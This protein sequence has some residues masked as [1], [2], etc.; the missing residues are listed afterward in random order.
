MHFGCGQQERND[1]PVD[2]CGGLGGYPKFEIP[3]PT[4]ERGRNSSLIISNPTA[5]VPAAF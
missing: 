3:L 2:D 4:G 1:A 5:A